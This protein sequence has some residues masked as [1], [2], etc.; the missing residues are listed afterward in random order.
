MFEFF[1]SFNVRIGLEYN[2]KTR[3]GVAMNFLEKKS[4]SENRVCGGT[5][6]FL[7]NKIMGNFGKRID[8]N[9][10]VWRCSV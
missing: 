9:S 5:Y 6:G 4:W 3:L 10:I 8:T 1:G 7:W 2:K